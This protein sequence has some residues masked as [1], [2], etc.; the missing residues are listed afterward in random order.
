MSTP[1]NQDN[2]TGGDN[3]NATTVVCRRCHTPSIEEIDP[4]PLF[5]HICGNCYRNKPYSASAGERPTRQK[6]H[7]PSEPS[8]A[9]ARPPSPGATLSMTKLKKYLDAFAEPTRKVQK[10]P[11]SFTKNALK[12]SLS[13]DKSILEGINKTLEDHP[14]AEEQEKLTK[15]K[16]MA[17]ILEIQNM[18]A[19]EESYSMVSE[20]PTS[21]TLTEL[22]YPF[23]K[24]SK[25]PGSAKM[26]RTSNPNPNFSLENSLFSRHSSSQSSRRGRGEHYSVHFEEQTSTTPAAQIIDTTTQSLDGKIG[27]P[28]RVN[29]PFAEEKDQ[30]YS[31]HA[32]EVQNELEPDTQWGITT[33]SSSPSTV[34]K[35]SLPSKYLDEYGT[36]DTYWQMYVK[37]EKELQGLTSSSTVDVLCANQEERPGN[38]SW[39]WGPVKDDGVGDFIGMAE[40]QRDIVKGDI[41]LQQFPASPHKRVVHNI[42]EEYEHLNYDHTH[43]YSVLVDGM[44]HEK[45]SR[46]FLWTQW[47]TSVQGDKDKGHNE[48]EENKEENKKVKKKKAKKMKKREDGSDDVEGENEGDKEEVHDEEVEE[49]EG[50]QMENS[51]NVNSSSKSRVEGFTIDDDELDSVISKYSL[52]TVPEPT[53]LDKFGHGHKEF[54]RISRLYKEAFLKLDMALKTTRI[55][56]LSDPIAGKLMTITRCKEGIKVIQ[57]AIRVGDE[58]DKWAKIE[59]ESFQARVKQSRLEFSQKVSDAMQQA[60][61]AQLDFKQQYEQASS[62]F[63]ASQASSKLFESETGTHITSNAKMDSIMAAANKDLI[64]RGAALQELQAMEAE[65]ALQLKEEEEIVI[66]AVRKWR[67]RQ[68]RMAN[69][70]RVYLRRLSAMM[71]NTAAALIQKN[72]RVFLLM[73]ASG[74]LYYHIYEEWEANNERKEAKAKAI[75]EHKESVKEEYRRI[76]A[77]RRPI[78]EVLKLPRLKGRAFLPPPVERHKGGGHKGSGNG[79]GASLGI[80]GVTNNL[81]DNVHHGPG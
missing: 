10:A 77:I 76:A 51:N 65:N 13:L 40:S 56:F 66:R 37:R 38:D 55:E 35:S 26:K 59:F 24:S 73:P 3:L 32:P 22:Q 75:K 31:E 57:D 80:T 33:S 69:E 4:P 46:S 14:T 9:S 67:P 50:K 5:C 2:G 64:T 45:F 44:N 47:L 17:D 1:E 74:H 23:S 27:S 79:N 25:G 21:R 15:K 70:C 58:A 7:S 18:M 60:S 43:A 11:K 12:M 63:E 68:F 29:T 49:K 71:A 54:A 30:Q 20:T 16:L 8:K 19:I 52:V 72:V 28:L 48:E 78:S 61:L 41:A 42:H 6:N 81:M 62:L 34:I 36:V 53:P 39:F